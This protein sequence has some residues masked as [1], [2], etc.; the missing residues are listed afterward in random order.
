MNVNIE[1]L[2]EKIARVP[3]LSGEAFPTEL[4]WRLKHMILSH[5]GTYEFGSPK[6]PMTPE[7]VALH[8]LDNLDAKVHAFTK[9]IE[10]AGKDAHWTPYNNL[11]QR[12]LYKG[13]SLDTASVD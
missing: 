1:I 11:L 5:H 4:M 6:L 3:E 9:E 8:H 13:A 7:A 2:N 10:D 12:K